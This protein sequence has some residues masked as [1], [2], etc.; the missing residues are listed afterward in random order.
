MGKS[1]AAF[2][3]CH[4]VLRAPRKFSEVESITDSARRA[5]ARTFEVSDLQISGERLRWTL[6]MTPSERRAP[7]AVSRIQAV[8]PE[9]ET[10]PTSPRWR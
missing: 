1:F 6:R 8:A 10:S 3:S 4:G 7:V 5:G 2:T 9:S